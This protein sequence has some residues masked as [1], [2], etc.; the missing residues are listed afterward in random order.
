MN[1][2]LLVLAVSGMNLLSFYLGSKLSSHEKIDV[3]LPNLNPISKYKECKETQE[4]KKELERN[5]I[6]MQNIDN[7]DGTSNGQKDVPM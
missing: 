6:I 3:K 7:Y 2:V 4:A 5:N 1:D